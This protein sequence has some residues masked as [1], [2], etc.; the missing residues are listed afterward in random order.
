MPSKLTVR[1]PSTAPARRTDEQTNAVA[2]ARGTDDRGPSARPCVWRSSASTCR[3][4][5]SQILSRAAKQAGLHRRAYGNTLWAARFASAGE[6]GKAAPRI[7][8]AAKLAQHGELWT[9]AEPPYATGTYPGE[10]RSPG[11][12]VLWQRGAWLLMSTLPEEETRL[13]RLQSHE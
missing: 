6:A 10:R 3:A 13:L 2:G 11:P 4:P 1:N 5:G 8:A 12:L 9:G 7:A